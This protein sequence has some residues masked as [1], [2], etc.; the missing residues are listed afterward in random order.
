MRLTAALR[1]EPQQQGD[2]DWAAEVAADG[3]GGGQQQQG[4]RDTQCESGLHPVSL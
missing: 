2:R 4:D 1:E 3:E